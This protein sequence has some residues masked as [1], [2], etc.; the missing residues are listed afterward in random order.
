MLII[1]DFDGT[2]AD[3]MWAW[4]ELGR[5]TLEEYNLPP[6]PDYENV[7]RSMSVPDFSVYLSGKYPVLGTDGQLMSVWHRKM[8]YNY[9]NRVKLKEGIIPFLDYLKKNKYTVYLASATHYSILI[10]A[11]EHFK[12]TEYFDFIIT[13]E[14][15]GISKRDPKIYDLCIKKANASKKDTIVFEDA[16]HAVKT[17]KAMG[18]KVC[19][20][21]DYSMRDHAG[22]VAE[23]ADL[24]I[25]D[26]T[27]LDA[28]IKFIS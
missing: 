13:E 26:F 22:E 11:L 12:L 19:A 6:L 1:F 14:V 27:D 24:V 8:L 16:V 21:S 25:D 20:V 7:I 18:I 28:L 15:V 10:Q 4:D 3:S 17:I 23:A 2:I 9:L 5:D